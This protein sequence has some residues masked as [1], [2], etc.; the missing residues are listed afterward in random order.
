MNTIES[1][2]LLNLNLLFIGQSL[3]YVTMY[4]KL[5][6]NQISSKMYSKPHLFGR[7]GRITKLMEAAILKTICL[8]FILTGCL[9]HRT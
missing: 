4:S 1:T 8:G 2:T 6:W 9:A 7:L 3:E 5:P